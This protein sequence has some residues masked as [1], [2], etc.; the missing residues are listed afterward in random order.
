M[1]RPVSAALP[2]LLSFGA[3]GAL[4]CKAKPPEITEPFSDDFERAEL[5]PAW[6]DTGGGYGIVGGKLHVSMAHNHPLWLRKR[7]PRNFVLEV[8]ATS[9]SPSGDLKVEVA[10]DGESFDPDGNRYVATGYVLIFG[11]WQN[12]RSII[13]RLDEHDDGEKVHRTEPRVEPGRT[14]HWT[15]TRKGED[16]DWKID[17]QP[18]LAWRDPAPLTGNGHEFFSFNNW[19]ADVTFDNLTI[20][21][22]P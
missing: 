1:S 3:A 18:F 19:E 12:R 7:L 2:V 16:L 13:A 15:I 17:G 20:R 5:G 14:Y 6:H 4:G 21:P 11:G 8:D 22:L 9:N 10:G